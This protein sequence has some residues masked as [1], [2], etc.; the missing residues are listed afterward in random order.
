MFG[1]G[2]GAGGWLLMVLLTLALFGAGIGCA[3]AFWSASHS[4]AQSSRAMD[5]LAERFA[6]GEI[7]IDEY[8]R[9]REALQHPS[10]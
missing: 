5:V 3:F 8:R 6:S 4:S 1:Y 7:D 10:S 2:M 9:R